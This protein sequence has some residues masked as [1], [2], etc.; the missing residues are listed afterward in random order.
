MLF[1]LLKHYGYRRGGGGGAGHRAA[2]RQRGRPPIHCSGLAGK[3]SRFSW[4]NQYVATSKHR[5]FAPS[6]GP[7]VYLLQY[8]PGSTVHTVRP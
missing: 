3:A 7:N 1:F 6:S 5:V 4:I 2:V 8:T